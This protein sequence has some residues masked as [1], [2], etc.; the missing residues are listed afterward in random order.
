M[1][2]LKKIST[3]TKGF[4]KKAEQD[5]ERG[6]GFFLYLEDNNKD[7][8]ENY[9]RIHLGK[10][11]LSQKENEEEELKAEMFFLEKLK[12]DKDYKWVS[13]IDGMINDMKTSQSLNSKF[14]KNSIANI[15]FS[16]HII[17]TI[18]WPSY[19]ITQLQLTQDMEKIQKKI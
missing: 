17:T 10:R 11:L 13:K 9:Y 7:V 6:I 12:Q 8:F 1:E 3:D 14:D 18:Y 15:S 16:A 4:D 19:P 2:E 5:L